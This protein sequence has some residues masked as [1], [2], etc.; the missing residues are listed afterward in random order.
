MYQQQPSGYLRSLSSLARSKNITTYQL[1]RRGASHSL[2][3]STTDRMT[4]YICR[5]LVLPSIPF[6]F[7]SIH[8]LT[9]LCYRLLY[10]I[11]V[12]TVSWYLFPH[13]PP[14]ASLLPPVFVL[15]MPLLLDEKMGG[16]REAIVLRSSFRHVLQVVVPVCVFDRQC[17]MAEAAAQ[18]MFQRVCAQLTA[19]AGAIIHRL[20]NRQA[21]I[22][23]WIDEQRD[24]KIR[25][26]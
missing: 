26:R 16:N 5:V 4:F 11:N 13:L 8:P 21:Y 15:L 18:Q 3:C 1:R 22:A 24:R 17:I 6:P 25:Y 23:R 7:L 10:D 9:F 19:A 12:Y 20:Y 2:S 14:S